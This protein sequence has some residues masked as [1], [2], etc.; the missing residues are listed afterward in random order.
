MTCTRAG[1]E[2][3]VRIS[4]LLIGLSIYGVAAQAQDASLR[5]SLREGAPQFGFRLGAAVPLGQ[6]NEFVG[7]GGQLDGSFLFNPLKGRDLVA[8]RLD[9]TYV[10]YGSETHTV[11]LLPSTERILVDVTTNNNIVS[12]AVGPQITF[13][14][15]AVRPYI[16]GD[17]GFSYFFTESSASGSSSGGEPFAS[18]TNYDDFTAAFGGDAG[19]YI[20]LS[21]R[22]AISLDLSLRYQHNATVRYLHE[23]SI[24]EQPDG[25]IR[26]TPNE[27]PVDLLLLRVG[28][29]LGSRR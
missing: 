9:V 16:G 4:H 15:R 26:F 6:F 13:P 10:I 24:Q 22:K 2:S 1:T 21:R 11:P 5:G 25:S 7:V 3:F 14:G 17:V 8:L 19:L 20:S 18:T 23:G 28:I 29:G 12:V 27:T